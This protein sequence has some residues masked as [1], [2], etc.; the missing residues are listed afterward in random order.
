MLR[1]LLLT[2]RNSVPWHGI[3]STV[4]ERSQSECN[5]TIKREFIKTIDVI[6]EKDISLRKKSL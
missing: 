1:E 2:E 3:D 5:E 6:I 4:L